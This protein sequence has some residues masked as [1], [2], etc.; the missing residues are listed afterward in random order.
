[1]AV[2]L[3]KPLGRIIALLVVLVLVA[4]VWFALEAHPLGGSGREEFVT[5][6][7]GDSLATIANEMHDKGVIS[8]TFAFRLDLTIF[9]SPTVIPGTYGMA[10]GASFSSLRSILSHEPNVVSVYSGYTLH[11]IA[12][13]VAQHTSNSFGDQFVADETTLAKESGFGSAGSLEGLVGPGNYVLSVGELPVELLDQMTANFSKLAKSVGLT[14]STHV[15]GL[16]AYQLIVG[17]SIDEKEG[18]YPANMPRVARVIYNR[19]ARGGPLQMDATV[20]YY[21]HQDGGTVTPAM[22]QTP[23]PYNTYL[24]AGLTPTPICTVSKYSLKAMLHAPAGSWLYFEL[25][26][27]NGTM[28]F[29]TTFAQQL[30]AEAKAA[31]NGIS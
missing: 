1:M 25:V 21:F 4:G 17:A 30:A 6:E 15:N 14:P 7:P 27:K 3:F 8:S 2:I 23:T 26:N 29:S 16:D 22:L 28:Q 24:N 13:E 18:Y 10:Q 5:V 31:K 12:Q 11:E 9:G 19:L 20:E